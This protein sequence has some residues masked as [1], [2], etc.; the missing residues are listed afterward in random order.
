MGQQAKQPLEE[1]D[2]TAVNQGCNALSLE[3]GSDNRLNK[4]PPI[5]PC[6]YGKQVLLCSQTLCTSSLP[7]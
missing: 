7:N 3:R 6:V 5:E 2:I 1:R 4:S